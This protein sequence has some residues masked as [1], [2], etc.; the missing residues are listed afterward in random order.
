[1]PDGR[2]N[3]RGT[4]GNKGGRP[5]KAD[6]IKVIETMDSVLAPVEAWKKLAD[7]VMQGDMQAIKLWLE[8]RIGKPTQSVDVT[9]GGDKLPSLTVEFIK[10][11][12]SK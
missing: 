2:K 7:L 5:P 12:E 8:Y 1:M 3:N 9:S 6:E 11:N 10:P 4:P